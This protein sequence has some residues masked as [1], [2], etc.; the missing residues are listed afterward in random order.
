MGKYNGQ[1]LGI[2]ARGRYITRGINNGQRVDITARVI[3]IIT[4]G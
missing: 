2:M 1:R 4:G 3:D